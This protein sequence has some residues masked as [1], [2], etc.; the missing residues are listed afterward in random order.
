MAGPGHKREGQNNRE[1]WAGRALRSCEPRG[2]ERGPRERAEWL[3][4]CVVLV[5][6]RRQRQCRGLAAYLDHRPRPQRYSMS[7]AAGASSQRR[8]GEN[9]GGPGGQSSLEVVQSTFQGNVAWP[10]GTS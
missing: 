4:G 5:W 7:S 8:G 3:E 6:G 9:V 2:G 10:H 1:N